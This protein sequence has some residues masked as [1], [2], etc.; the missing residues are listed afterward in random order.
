MEEEIELVEVKLKTWYVREW[1]KAFFYC[2]LIE[3]KYVEGHGF[4]N[5]EFCSFL[6]FERGQFD[7]EWKIINGED[8]E[9]YF[10]K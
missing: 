9:D 4:I 8:I 2:E 1:D 3:D 6:H 5:D 10:D 7:L